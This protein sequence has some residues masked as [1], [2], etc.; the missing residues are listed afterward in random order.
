[1]YDSLNITSAVSALTSAGSSSAKRA[2][3]IDSSHMIYGN[4][5]TLTQ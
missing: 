5:M 2:S 3:V 4:L 1:M